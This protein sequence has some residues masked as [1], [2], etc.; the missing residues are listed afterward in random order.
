MNTKP[1]TKDIASQVANACA[2]NALRRAA[3]KVSRLYDNALKPAGIKNTQL[4]MLSAVALQK[5]VTL[6]AL[7]DSLAM[8]RTT[9][10]RNL[11][12]LEKNGWIKVSAE[13]YRRTRT[14]DLTAK[15]NKVLQDA[16]PLW[17]T[18]QESIRK[19][20]GGKDLDVLSAELKRLAAVI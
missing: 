1:H 15:G 12:P 17:K 6:T 11:A 9:L 4:T 18:A 20:M 5:D 7:A 8:E 10:L 19:K 16:L 2:C 14:V 3:R 13:G